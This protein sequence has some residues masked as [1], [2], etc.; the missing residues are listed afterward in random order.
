[1]AKAWTN[2]LKDI[3]TGQTNLFDAGRKLTVAVLQLSGTVKVVQA[4]RSTQWSAYGLSGIIDEL[5]GNV[6]TCTPKTMDNW[7][8][9]LYSITSPVDQISMA[10]ELPDNSQR[11]RSRLIVNKQNT[12]P[13]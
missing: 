4:A 2:T 10:A 5:G 8:V 1:M 12:Y 11:K 13:I 3:Q 9:V 6:G 7:D